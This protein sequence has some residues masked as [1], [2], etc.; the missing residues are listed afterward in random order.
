MKKLI[1]IL[2]SAIILFPAFTLAAASYAWTQQTAARSHQWMSVAMSSDGNTIAAVGDNHLYI[3]T[4]GGTTWTDKTPATA[5]PF[6]VAMS[7]NGTYIV[8]SGNS[9]NSTVPIFISSDGG[10]T[11]TSVTGPVSPGLWGSMTS[12]SDGTH[13]AAVTPGSSSGGYIYTSTNG[14]Y[15]WTAQTSAGARAWETIASSANGT[16]LIATATGGYP[17]CSSGAGGIFVSTNGGA[18]WTCTD[19]GSG[20]SGL[21]PTASSAD[22]THLATG[23]FYGLIYTSTTTGATWNTSG[24]AGDP[25]S[26]L[27]SSSDGSVLA[28][29]MGQGADQ[30]WI[31]LD[32]GSTWTTQNAPS[33]SGWNGLVS[34]SDGT[35]L[36]AIQENGYLY[37]ALPTPVCVVGLSP[38]PSPYSYSG[39]PVTLSWSS[40]NSDE[41]YITN[42]G[43][44]NPTGSTQVASQQN[45]S[46]SCYGYS[47]TFGTGTTTAAS[48]SVT[49]PTAPTVTISASSTSIYTNQSANVTAAFSA[50]SGVSSTP[51]VIYLTSGSSWPVPSNWNSTSNTIEVLGGGSSGNMT[52]SLGSDATGGGGAYSKIT[53]LYLVRNSTVAYGVGA[54]GAGVTGLT[55]NPGGDTWFNATSMA[56]CVT[57]G[58]GSCVGTKG[59]S[60]AGPGVG[61]IGGSASGGVGTVSYSGGNGWGGSNGDGGGGAAGPNGAGGNGSATAGGSADGGTVA[62]PT[63]SRGRN[64]SGFSGSE[65]ASAGS[66]TG[67]YFLLTS[68]GSAI[69]GQ[70][71]GGGGAQKSGTSSAGGAGLIVITYYPLINGGAGSGDALTADNIDQ[72]YGAGQG[73]TTNPDASKT[74]SFST[75]TPGTYTFYALATTDAYP[76]W[77]TYASTTITVLAA[78]SCTAATS[79]SC[80][81]SGNSVITQTSTSTSCAVTV[82]NLSTCTSPQF[83]QSGSSQ[84]LAPAIAFNQSGNFTGHLQIVPNLL[85][86]GESTQVYWNVSDAQSCQVTGSNG[87]SWTGLSSPT[88]GETSKPITSETTYTLSCTAYGSN[89]NVSESQ[90]V[91]VTPTFEEK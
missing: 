24:A 53:D 32:S 31:S 19:D 42:V 2:S 39:T 36:A 91:N 5:A 73:A 89:S 84:C 35:H 62:G 90:A 85:G 68:T 54:G 71:G 15:T 88:K 44:V 23:E 11:W 52:N 49:P 74:I 50:G 41:V 77:T 82:T 40:N 56:N 75:T 81:G 20:S 83:C 43:W 72:P 76:S 14:G 4:N 66:G 48:L 13:L 57:A 38:N 28:A 26:F 25:W 21:A 65:W 47:A 58:A 37:T 61:G 27:S 59:A 79:Y 45:T 29:A 6:L 78:P 80:T 3:S 34:S 18:N 7:S 9:R 51:T 46:Y 63:S 55:G 1:I 22:G 70:Y 69:G 8:L 64:I 86:K 60:A 10:S 67:A 87:D 12:S 16:I 30:I 33:T 17:Q